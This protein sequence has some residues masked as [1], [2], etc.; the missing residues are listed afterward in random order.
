M[1]RRKT[2]AQLT[3]QLLKEDT[4]LKRKFV[5]DPS[6]GKKKKT[7]FSHKHKEQIVG[8]FQLRSSLILEVQPD[9]HS[10]LSN[11]KSKQNI[12][13]HCKMYILQSLWCAWA[14]G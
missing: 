12:S 11:D 2:L 5:E 3:L 14:L 7:F 1:E 6:V 9:H 13:M 4:K 8:R 10:L